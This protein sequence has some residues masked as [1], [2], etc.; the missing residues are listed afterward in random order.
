MR[1][2]ADEVMAAFDALKAANDARLDRD[3]KARERRTRLIED[4]LDRI[5]K[6]DWTATKARLDRMALDACASGGFQMD[7][8]K[9]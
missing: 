1:A 3:R 2:V 4:K 9:W 5:E 6:C 7:V 8:R